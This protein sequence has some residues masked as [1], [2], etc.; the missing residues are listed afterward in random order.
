MARA[1]QQA[2]LGQAA[3]ESTRF[4]AFFRVIQIIAIGTALLT[5]FYTFRAYFLTFWGP[6]KFP[7]EAGH[8]PHD[9]SSVMA[10]PLGVLAVCAAGIGIL[11]GP[12]HL[13][14]GTLQRIQGLT[15]VESHGLHWGVMAI[16]SLVALAGIAAA[17]FCY[18]AVPT[19]PGRLAAGLRPL[20]VLSSRKFCLDEIFQALVVFPLR[21][22]AGLAVL[23]DRCV[24]DGLVDAAGSIPR[25]LSR[26]PRP[27]HS[28][29][30][31]AYAGYMWIGLAVTVVMVLSFF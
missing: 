25:T 11:L 5:A 16:S 7:E 23:V 22:L 3:A 27:L 15:V 8:H 2:V 4:G 19:I 10:W 14:A 30:L 24:I 29:S 21:G 9:A 20:Y 31:S 12:T 17:W 26:V 13:F 1:P 6:P 18:V 28:G